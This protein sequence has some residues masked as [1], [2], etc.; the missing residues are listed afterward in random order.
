MGVV[1]AAVAGVAVAAQSRVNSDLA[2]QLGDGLAAAAISFGTATLV[3]A[4]A[5]L[6][7][8]VGRRGLARL[9][10]GIRTRL[11]RPWQCLGGCCGAALVVTQS[12]TVPWTGVAIFSVAM[13]AGQ[14]VGGLLVD[15]LGAGPAGPQRLTPTRVA[16]AGLALAAA[17]I[18]A[19]DHV[20]QLSDLR[21]LS[22]VLLPTAA[23]VGIAWQQAVNGRIGEAAGPTAAV[24]V[25]FLAG[26]AALLLAIIVAVSARGGPTGSLP[27]QPWPYLGGLIGVVIIAIGVAVVPH[28]GV[29]LLTLGMIAGQLAGAIALDIVALRAG[30]GPTTLW[31]LVGASLSLLAVL[32]TAFRGTAADPRPA[33]SAT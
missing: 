27:S 13:V 11:V 31:T 9:R 3:L 32:A 18:A 26:S 10:A 6:A 28:V 30:A 19:V 22:L 4:S 24:F 20:D 5:V 21:S 29:L 16:G 15:R 8:R 1:L 2:V 17:F 12:T 7:T 23:G 33:R 25:S 14:T